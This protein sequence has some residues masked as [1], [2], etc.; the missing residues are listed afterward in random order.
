MSIRRTGT[1]N[2]RRG[3]SAV[4]GGRPAGSI[5]GPN[6]VASPH[7]KTDAGGTGTVSIRPGSDGDLV[8]AT[9]GSPRGASLEPAFTRL[10]DARDVKVQEQPYEIGARFRREQHGA[11]RMLDESGVVGKLSYRHSHSRP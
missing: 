2:F 9:G 10:P 3:N 1:S 11:R 7:N 5:G 4:E 6:N 8:G